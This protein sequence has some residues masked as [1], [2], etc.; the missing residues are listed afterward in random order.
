MSLRGTMA[1]AL[2]LTACGGDPTTPTETGGEP[3]AIVG[4]YVDEFGTE[5]EITEESWTQTF[6]DYDP[7]VFRIAGWDDDEQWLV[8]QNDDANPFNPGAWSRFDWVDPGD[9]HLYYCQTAYDAP[10]RPSA[11]DTLRPDDADPATGG[12]GGFPWTDLRP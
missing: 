3:L 9:G 4:S 11:E 2:A 7:S 12:C 1:A 6:G 10:D 5:H 8:A